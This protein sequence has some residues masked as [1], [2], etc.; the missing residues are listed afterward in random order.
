M[1]PGTVQVCNGNYGKNGWLGLASIN[2]SGGHITQGSAKMN[3]SYFSSATYNNP[4][5]KLQVMCQEVAHTFGLGYQSEDGSSQNSCM[6]Y[7]SNTG[8]NAGSTLSTTPNAHDFDDLNL[9]YG[10][11]DTT[12][13]VAATTAAADAVTDEPKSWGDLKAQNKSGKGSV[14]ERKLAD[15]SV[16]ITHVLLDGRSRRQMRQLRPSQQLMSER[17]C[18]APPQL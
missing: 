10:H 9:I 4:N 8:V 7:F 3:D 13:T 12:T 15:D 14:Y 5:E 1:V 11:L 6:D 2:I 17:S 18:G 16:T